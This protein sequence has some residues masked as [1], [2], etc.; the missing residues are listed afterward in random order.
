MAIRN[1]E[2]HALLERTNSNARSRSILQKLWSTVRPHLDTEGSDVSIVRKSLFFDAG[3][4]LETYPDV[5]QCRI[6]PAVHYVRHGAREGRDP[7]PFFSTATYRRQNLGPGETNLNPLVHFETVGRIKGCALVASC[8]PKAV[9][10]QDR[11][12]DHDRAAVRR[13]IASFTHKPLLS[14]CMVVDAPVDAWFREAL[15]SVTAQRY[16]LWE[17]RA[18]FGP[19]AAPGVRAILDAVAAEEHRVHLLPLEADATP[20]ELW[21]AALLGA[22]GAFVIPLGQHDRLHETALYEIAN[23]INTA[24]DVDILYSDED[25]LDSAGQ[26]GDPHFKTGFDPDLLLGQNLVGGLAA[27]RTPLVSQ[28]GGFRAGLDGAESYDLALRAIAATSGKRIRHIPELLYHCRAPGSGVDTAAARRRAA[29]DLLCQSGEAG[30][31]QPHPRN[32]AWSRVVRPLPAPAPL[33]SVIVLTK[34]RADLLAVCAKGILEQTDYPNIELIIVDHASREDETHQLFSRLRADA[35]VRIVPYA[36]AFNYSAMNNLAARQANGSVIA[37]LNNDIEVVDPAWLSEMV[38]LAVRP[39]VGAVGAKLY[40]PDGTIQHAGVVAGLGG[41][42]GHA[43][44][45]QPGDTLGSAGRAV[46]TR[47]VSAVTAACL[48]VRKSVFL[49]AG[50]LNADDLPVAFNDIDLCFRLQAAGYRNVWTPFAELVH[51][52]SASR[53]KEETPAKKERFARD[54]AYMLAHWG[55]IIRNDP[56]YNPNLSLT[57]GDYARAPSRRDRPWKDFL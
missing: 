57:S 15:A 28:M 12:H 42:A 14:V 1:S 39:D 13:H 3:W 16:P 18:A 8:E 44:S 37:L 25:T 4:Y 47:T 30:T 22:R 54:T 7:S 32:P 5:A 9:W 11:L 43:F 21:N 35:R 50:G 26:H 36:G 56:Y 19:A 40:Y 23:A 10:W 46:L 48:V 31:V 20:A 51:H 24:P 55:E 34:D 33:V 41:A 38:S 52:E 17:F 29:Q 45:F 49:D 53:G 6:D 27:F 2:Q